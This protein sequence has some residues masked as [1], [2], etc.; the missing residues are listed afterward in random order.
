MCRGRVLGV[1]SG[2]RQGLALPFLDSLQFPD[3]DLPRPYSF[4]AIPVYKDARSFFLIPIRDTLK[5][6]PRERDLEKLK[7]VA[8]AFISPRYNSL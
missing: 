8:V 2:A 4:L 5:F 3:G 1:A 7:T 6:G